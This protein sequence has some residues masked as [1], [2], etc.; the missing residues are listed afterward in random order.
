MRPTIVISVTP[1][2]AAV[3][4]ALAGI[5]AARASTEYVAIIA[6]ALF[7]AAVSTVA[8]TAWRARQAWQHTQRTEQMQREA[9]S[10]YLAEQRRHHAECHARN[11]GQQHIGV[12]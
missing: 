12:N 1:G 8:I 2:L 11:G 10:E 9:V 3:F 6:A 7:V 5:A 4:G